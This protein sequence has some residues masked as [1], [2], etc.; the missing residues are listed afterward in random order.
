M[1]LNRFVSQNGKLSKDKIENA[2][3]EGYPR[4]EG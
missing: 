3:K 4:V 1:E 2:G